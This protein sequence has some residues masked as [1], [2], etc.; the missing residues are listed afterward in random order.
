MTKIIV[1]MTSSSSSS[2]SSNSRTELSTKHDDESNETSKI[3][4]HKSNARASSSSLEYVEENSAKQPYHSR[5]SSHDQSTKT[6]SHVTRKGFRSPI[7]SIAIQSNFLRSSPKESLYCL[8]PTVTNARPFDEFFLGSG[9]SN[10]N[11]IISTKPDDNRTPNS[12]QK[13]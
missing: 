7:S 8:R 9:E 2:S 11:S 3:P 13:S 1:D 5:I 12:S 6:S 4:H 10:G